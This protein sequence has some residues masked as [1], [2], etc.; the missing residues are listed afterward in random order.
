MKKLAIVTGANRGIGEA[1]AA[2]LAKKGL[3]VIGTDR[4]MLDVSDDASID[5]FVASLDRARGVDV[6]V[7]NA[8]V[9]LDGFDA[10]VVRQTLRV[11]LVGAMHLTDRLLPFFRPEARIVMLSSGMGELSVIPSKTLRER[12][13]SPSLDRQGLLA[14]TDEFLAA[15]ASGRRDLGGFPRS[16]YSVSKVALNAYV[17]I[18]ARELASDPRHLAVNAACPGWVRTQMG[19]RSAPRSVEQ[20]AKTPVFLSLLEGPKAPTGRFFRDEREVDF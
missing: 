20:G 17:R 5:R 14:I 16:A 12:F 9:A 7:N 2:S 8:G 13:A 3:E 10:D 4:K 18:L 6:L 1:I 11:N 15:V 19:G